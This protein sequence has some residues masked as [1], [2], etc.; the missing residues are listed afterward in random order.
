MV[1]I[2]DKDPY[3]HEYYR[4]N[5]AVIKRQAKINYYKRRWKRDVYFIRESSI[6]NQIETK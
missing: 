4:I 1:N 6:V 3:A 5:N 2:L